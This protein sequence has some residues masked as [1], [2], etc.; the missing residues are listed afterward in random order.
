MWRWV[1]KNLCK[2][3]FKD[4]VWSATLLEGVGRKKLKVI[5]KNVLNYILVEFWSKVGVYYGFNS[6]LKHQRWCRE[7][8]KCPF[9]LLTSSSPLVKRPILMSPWRH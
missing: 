1:Q 7:E 6:E 8:K 3:N 5:S 4:H 9:I 2:T